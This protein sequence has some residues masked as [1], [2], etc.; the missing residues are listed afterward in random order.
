MN[1]L[2]TLSIYFLSTEVKKSKWK[3]K[4]VWQKIWMQYF[5]DDLSGVV[6]LF[7]NI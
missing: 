3:L 1:P 5:K 7:Y 6:G 4:A 2:L